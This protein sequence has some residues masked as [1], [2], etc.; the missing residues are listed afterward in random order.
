MAY[1]GFQRS[2]S[3]SPQTLALSH[4]SNGLYSDKQQRSTLNGIVKE[5]KKVPVESECAEMSS[6][7]C[8][9]LSARSSGFSNPPP[10]TFPK[11]SHQKSHRRQV[12]PCLNGSQY[13]PP[14]MLGGYLDSAQGSWSK[15]ANPMGPAPRAAELE[16]LL[17][18]CTD[19]WNRGT[20]AQ[21]G[22]GH[23]RS[24]VLR[25]VLALLVIGILISFSCV[26][27]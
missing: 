13:V 5:L 22:R 17:A 4:S 11:Q 2:A 7:I 18:V 20:L 3:A 26:T 21:A 12:F 15:K 9:H 23:R 6:Y 16:A 27:L 25:E 19:T 10:P 14:G 1:L 24:W 8:H